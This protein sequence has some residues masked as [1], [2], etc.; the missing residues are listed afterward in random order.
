MKPIEDNVVWKAVKVYIFKFAVIL[1]LGFV[2]IILS[3]WLAWKMYDGD[4]VSSIGERVR[5]WMNGGEDA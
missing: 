2:F 4:W 5:K 3:P 1:S